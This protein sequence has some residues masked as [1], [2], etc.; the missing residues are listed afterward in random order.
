MNRHCFLRVATGG[1]D[2]L[3]DTGHATFGPRNCRQDP[4][5]ARLLEE[6]TDE[7]TQ[8]Q[9]ELMAQKEELIVQQQELADAKQRPRAP[10][11]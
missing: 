11:K 10:R 7:L 1:R 4:G 8:S 2:E 3:G 9:Q 6:Q 5:A